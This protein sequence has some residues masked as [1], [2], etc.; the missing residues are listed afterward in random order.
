MGNEL[1]FLAQLSSKTD[2]EIDWLLAQKILEKFEPS[3]KQLVY[4]LAIPHSFNKKLVNRL[5]DNKNQIDDYYKSI[6]NLPFIQKYGKI[7]SNIRS[8]V[9]DAIIRNYFLNKHYSQLADNSKQ[10]LTFLRDLDDYKKGNA[11]VIVETYYLQAFIEPEVASEI[12]DEL[13]LKFIEEEDVAAFKDVLLKIKELSSFGILNKNNKERYEKVDNELFYAEKNDNILRRFTNRGRHDKLYIPFRIH[14]QNTGISKVNALKEIFQNF[15]VLLQRREKISISYYTSQ[16]EQIISNEEHLFYYKAQLHLLTGD[17]DIALNLVNQLLRRNAEKVEYCRLRGIIYR[18][19]FQLDEALQEFQKVLNAGKQDQETLARKGEVLQELGDQEQAEELLT[20]ADEEQD[21]PWV[22]A[23]MGETFLLKGQYLQAIECLNEALSRNKQLTWAYVDRG[24]ALLHLNKT[25]DATKNFDDAIELDSEYSW[26][27]LQKGLVHRF[28]EEYDK[29]IDNFSYVIDHIDPNYELAYAER[30]LTFR[31][32]NDFENAIQDFRNAL[33][34]KDKLSDDYAFWLKA[35]LGTTYRLMGNCNKAIEYLSKA[36]QSKPH[37][38]WAYAQRGMA[39]FQNKDYQ[40]ALND[41]FLVIENN[42]SEDKANKQWTY[43]RRGELRIEIDELEK[44]LEDFNAAIK[45]D[46]FDEF[47]HCNKGI[48]LLELGHDTEDTQQQKKYMAALNSFFRALDINDRFTSAKLFLGEAYTTVKDYNLAEKYYIKAIADNPADPVG[49]NMRGVL[50]YDMERYYEAIND[51]TKATTYDVDESFDEIYCNRGCVYR[52]LNRPHLAIDDFLTA[53]NIDPT[54]LNNYLEYAIT[55]KYIDNVEEAMS[56]FTYVIDRAK[57]EGSYFD[58]TIALA[59]RAELFWVMNEYNKA[60][61]DIENELIHDDFLWAIRQKG[62]ISLLLSNL[63]TARTSFNAILTKKPKDIFSQYYLSLVY[64][65]ANDKDGALKKLNTSIDIA[66]DDSIED[67]NELIE[68]D[69]ENLSL[70][71]FI[72]ICDLTK[73][74]INNEHSEVILKDLEFKL[75]LKQRNLYAHIQQ[76]R[77]LYNV[78]KEREPK[79][80][81]KA[82]QVMKKYQTSKH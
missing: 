80:L 59:H 42:D 70:D 52:S 65:Q 23:Q 10:I 77:V 58:Y 34:I 15:T 14:P 71:V 5:L 57:E 54:D 64:I 37:F 3:F 60:L 63:E 61:D 74:I 69:D 56:Y 81:D 29:A 66:K 12:F 33:N 2:S 49:Y 7:R 30:G 78:F 26:A 41:F 17:V 35:Q 72:N 18:E 50:Y 51:F 19:K 20:D 40:N 44:A 75:N 32:K 53:I 6:M 43:N 39:F 36:I 4:K 46:P 16:I 38:Y 82:F 55:L 13:G 67:Y 47:A 79:E 31:Y 24:I 8:D 73:A 68:E 28:L 25:T 9:R 76:I 45:L 48:A 1:N 21:I 27:Y 11:A 62:I 22:Q